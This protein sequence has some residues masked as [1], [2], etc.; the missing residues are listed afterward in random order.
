MPGPIS[1]KDVV[2]KKTVTIPEGVFEV[3]NEL[4][5]THWD[6]SSATVKL[7]DVCAM[8]KARN[9]AY[10]EAHLNVEESYRAAG[11]T[12]AYDRP[13]YYG[14]ENFEPYFTFKKRRGRGSDD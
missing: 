11:W 7:A 4:I 13:V 5:A 10:T 2:K 9:V 8:L 6:G 1:P 3:F 14:G 12:V